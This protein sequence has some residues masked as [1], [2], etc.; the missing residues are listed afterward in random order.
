M[1]EQEDKSDVEAWKAELDSAFQH[2]LDVGKSFGSHY[3]WEEAQRAYDMGE[4]ELWLDFYRPKTLE[5]WREWDA[6]HGK[7]FKDRWKREAQD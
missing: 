6:E 5:A 1:E 2:G 3:A 4:I 7:N